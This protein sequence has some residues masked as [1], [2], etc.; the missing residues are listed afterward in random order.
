ME[1]I[2]EMK[3]NNIIAKANEIAN[4]CKELGIGNI[5]FATNKASIEDKIFS[6]EY[7]LNDIKQLISNPLALKAAEKLPI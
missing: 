5:H 1:V 2:F 3:L 4:K 6:I 7:C